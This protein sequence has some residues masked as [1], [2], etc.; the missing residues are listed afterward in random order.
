MAV[1]AIGHY[2]LLEQIGAGGMGEVFRAKDLLLGR[3]VAIKRLRPDF[4]GNDD[5]R[6]RFLKEARAASSLD[7][8][9]IVCI[10][11]LLE[12]DGREYLVMEYIE[13]E[14]LRAH[15]ARG[16]L[17]VDR[18]VEIALQVAGA[19]E[20]AHRA[21]IVHR[22]LKPSNVM[23]CCDGKVK[24]LDFGLAKT[25]DVRPITADQATITVASQDRSAEGVLAGTAA[26]MSPE[27]AEG[28]KVDWRSDI[29]S[30]GAVLYEMLTGRQAFVGRSWT[31]TI[32]AI[33][34]QHPPPIRQF[35]RVP[36]ELER[37]VS[38]CLLK[39]PSK[40]LQ[41]VDD[42]RVELE[43]LSD[44]PAV[45][46]PN[47]PAGARR[48]YTVA[49]LIAVALMA[50]VVFAWSMLRPT[51][52]ALSHTA[53]L[54]QVTRDAGLTTT[55][56]LS[57]D[58][59]L[60]AYASDR[61]STGNL[62]I[63][64]QQLPTGGAVRLTTNAAAEYAPRFAPDG[65]HILFRS[66]AGGASG[67]FSIPALGGKPR[68][69]IAG[70][71][72]A[73]YSPDGHQLLYVKGPPGDF[74]R[75]QLFVQ[76]AEGGPVRRLAPDFLAASGGIWSPDSE[77]ILF[78]G[79]NP[80]NE[81]D[82]WLTTPSGSR[83]VAVN[84]KAAFRANSLSAAAPGAWS[85]DGR[86]I[87]FVA[88]KGAASNIWRASWDPLRKTVS[89]P[90]RVTYGT[91]ESQLSLARDG[92]VAFFSSRDTVS[93]WGVRLDPRTG[94]ATTAPERLTSG[95]GGE[96]RSD[97]SADG[98]S[99]ISIST[100]DGTADIWIRDL[101]TGSE[102]NVT[103][104]AMVEEQP[105][106][107]R[108][109]KLVAYMINEHGRHH[110]YVTPAEGGSPELRCDHCGWPLDWTPDSS[111][112]LYAGGSLEQASIWMVDADGR[113]WPV[114]EEKGMSLWAGRLSPNGKWVAFKRDVDV[115]RSRVYVAPIITGQRIPVS[116]WIPITAGEQWDDLPRW[117]HDGRLIYML[118]RRDGMACVWAQA[119]DDA[120]K[121][122]V[123]EPFGVLHLHQMRLIPLPDIRLL[124][125]AVGG[126][127]L[128]FPGLEL[129]GNIW[130][131]QPQ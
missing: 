65:S 76:P 67:I 25:D 22:D 47:G 98:R 6:R 127:R 124:E 114:V 73:C 118:S 26:Y 125:M 49:A 70:A 110:L 99:L 19:L 54:I 128:V 61:A 52:A 91:G 39:Q 108:D 94:I 9:N 14:T 97:L 101:E 122:P 62:D 57:P 4:F 116:S 79:I 8:P 2:E 107:S 68:P 12:S 45:A 58:G 23:V 86:Y 130:L 131:H 115:S 119:I 17:A 63:W 18:A 103:A 74:R 11:D 44:A 7:H 40:R 85:A 105:K 117:S 69:V 90:E 109:G 92:R 56:A 51:A 46:I 43:N 37:L 38:L 10:H 13:G 120:T 1:L 53:R 95:A 83:P 5:R 24:L 126:D 89:A 96:L 106:L 50:L 77:S 80:S 15:L 55:P 35:A 72:D 20:A 64:V 36:A 3:V 33:L 82:W 48:R 60:I 112:I 78:L 88:G 100:R 71:T 28:L 30:F 93:I 121:R 16:P 87:Y 42:I 123:G 32:A 84:A 102:H 21:G 81:V 111:G 27:Q 31:A 104:N 34:T 41:H 66:D 129:T 75:T 113:R 59:K 29:F